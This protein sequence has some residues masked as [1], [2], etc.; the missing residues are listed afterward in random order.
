MI[1]AM[2][3]VITQICN[4]DGMQI[5][6]LKQRVHVEEVQVIAYDS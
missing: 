2:L 5:N 6:F 3:Y 1:E 4:F